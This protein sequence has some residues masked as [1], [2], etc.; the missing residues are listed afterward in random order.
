MT[1]MCPKADGRVL[2][3]CSVCTFFE[4]LKMYLLRGAVAEI[5]SKTSYSHS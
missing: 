1:K 5:L 3:L 2:E 4:V